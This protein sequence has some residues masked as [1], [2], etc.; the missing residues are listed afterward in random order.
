MKTPWGSQLECWGFGELPMQ[1]SPPF[2]GDV[3]ESHELRY[4]LNSTTTGSPHTDLVSTPDQPSHDILV[5]QP[6]ICTYGTSVDKDR[7]EGIREHAP[8]YQYHEPFDARRSERVRHTLKRICANS[9]YYRPS[10]LIPSASRQSNVN[11]EHTGIHASCHPHR[12]VAQRI[13]PPPHGVSWR[14]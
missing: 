12:L 7:D 8:L 2:D 1:G 9:V 11:L 4:T 3:E 13:R 6:Y 10:A 14:I 5:N